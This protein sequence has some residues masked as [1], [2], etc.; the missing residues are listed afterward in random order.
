[1]SLNIIREGELKE[2]F[3]A[4]EEAFD[5]TGTDYY[6]I[7]AFA[8][9]IW[10]TRGKKKF[11]QTKDV[12]FA[13]LVGSTAEYEAIKEYLKQHKNFQDTKSNSFVLF[14]PSGLQ[15]DILPFG[16]I[17]IADSVDI[18]G[19]G[20]TNIKVN[21]FMEVYQAG[22]AEIGTETGHNFKVATLPS[23]VLLKL[24]AYDD[25]PEKRSKDARDIANI[26]T[27]F[28]DLQAEFI[29]THHLDLFQEENDLNLEEISAI[30]IGREI[31]TTVLSNP[32]LLLRLQTI[33]KTQLG[34]QEES[35]FIRNMVAETNSSVETMV[36]LM[37]HI[38]SSLTTP[39]H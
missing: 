3:D 21:G 17:E 12:D 4:L 7:G 24:I 10:Y 11:R 30:I 9:D 15:I 35:P 39:K 25:R 38:L 29:Y 8:R 36:K 5:A 2:V 37:Q 33:L 27:H 1:M 26:I 19:G 23:I 14:T 28:F 20:L 32:E 31:K 13:V 18:R 6:L 22:T 16:S 34:K